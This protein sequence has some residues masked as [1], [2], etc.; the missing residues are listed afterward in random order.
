ME[1]PLKGMMLYYVYVGPD[2]PPKEAHVLIDDLARKSQDLMDELSEA[3][4]KL[5]YVPVRTGES[6]V[7]LL[8]F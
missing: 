2:V 8:K 1:T 3:G 6:R 4:Y 5:L 7:E